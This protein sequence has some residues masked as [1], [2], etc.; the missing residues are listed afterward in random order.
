L[1]AFLIRKGG[2]IIEEKR[3][4]IFL[5]IQNSKQQLRNT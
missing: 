1:V 3:N 2:N 5:N 4:I